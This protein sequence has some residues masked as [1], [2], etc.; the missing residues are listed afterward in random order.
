MKKQAILRGLLL[1]LVIVIS[2]PVFASCK[3]DPEQPKDTREYDEVTDDPRFEKDD[4]PADLSFE[5]AEVHWMICDNQGVY[6]SFYVEENSISVVDKEIYNTTIRVESRLDIFL[7]FDYRS[8]TWDTRSNDYSLICQQIL[9]GVCEADIITARG[10]LPAYGGDTML[11]QDISELNY[12]DL[13]KPW[14]D[15]NLT[16]SFGSGTYMVTGDAYLGSVSSLSCI[17]FNQNFLNDHGVTE[18]LY[19]TVENGDWTL[20]KLETLTKDMYF[21]GDENTVLDDTYGVTFGDGSKY[22]AFLT[23]FNVNYYTKDSNDV[24]TYAASSPITVE[25]MDRLQSFNFNNSQVLPC[26]D[27]HETEEYSITIEGANRKINRAFQEGRAGFT[28]SIFDDAKYFYDPT[29]FKLGLLPYP[30]YDTQQSDYSISSSAIGFWIPTSASNADMSAAVLEAWSS[31]MY[32]SVIPVYFEEILQ[33]RYSAGSEMSAMFDLIRSVRT[34]KLETVISDPDLLNISA[35]SM[36]GYMTKH[37]TY[38]NKSW[39]VITTEN[40]LVTMAQL[41]RLGK[42]FGFDVDY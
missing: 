40:E 12:I 10:I 9:N 21:E 4:L 42:L 25:K 8:Y 41:E 27:V 17:Y 24:F 20:E 33:L 37:P 28:F 6:E 22:S 31:D 1:L 34:C 2:L 7:T 19:D 23:A 13:D 36:K 3:K 30:K 11:F 15:Q 38:G 39:T 14:W 32:R 29:G 26:I 5:N 18:D 16:G 35:W